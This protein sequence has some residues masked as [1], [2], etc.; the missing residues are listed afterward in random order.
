MGSA[1]LARSWHLGLCEAG[2]NG[3]DLLLLAQVLLLQVVPH[4]QL[5]PAFIA[6]LCK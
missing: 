3:E 4:P 2:G 5:L 6:P 1:L